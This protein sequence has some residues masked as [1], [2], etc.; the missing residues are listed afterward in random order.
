MEAP[1]PTALLVDWINEIVYL[2]ERDHWV[3]VDAEVTLDGH[4]AVAEV[5]GRSVDEA[6]S[7]VKAAT[8]HGVGV[9]AVHD[10]FEAE[11][12]LDI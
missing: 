6:P 2:A 12:V 5:S 4:T 11:V 9:Q 3:P 10:G 8:Y 7:F 1:D